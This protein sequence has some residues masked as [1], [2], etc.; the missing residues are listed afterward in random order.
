MGKFLLVAIS[1]ICLLMNGFSQSSQRDNSSD[2]HFIIPVK[3]HT[4]VSSPHDRK[5]KGSTSV[6]H[7]QA[8]L[9]LPSDY[10]PSGKPVRLVYCAHGA[11]GG[12]TESSWFLNNYAVV[13]TLL[14]N[15][16]AI[17][18]VNGGMSVE[19][20][21]GPLV[22]QSACNAY[23]Y[24]RKHYNVEKRIFVI[25]LSMGGLSSSNF[26]Y[27]Y[28]GV[29]LA[30]GLYSAVLDLYGQAWEHPWLP[31][32]RKAIANAFDFKDKSGNSWE[33]ERVNGWNPLLK[34]NTVHGSDTVKSYPVPVKI[35]HGKGD[36]IVHASFS[37]TFQRYILNAKGSC[38]LHEL[39]SA[40]HGLSCGNPEINHEMIQFFS[41]F[42]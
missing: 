36:P 15:G 21:G 31:T 12:V 4:S 22:V 5:R 9:K 2:I 20:M 6:F 41:K 37:K 1:L 26:I 17:F 23:R 8:I 29:V 30:Q 7:D 19:N 13:D 40:D 34:N 38:E 11:G 35:W 42:K 24:I 33:G 25:G 3:I 39:D 14:A 10:T 27:K 16:Y 18:D 32:T 28:P